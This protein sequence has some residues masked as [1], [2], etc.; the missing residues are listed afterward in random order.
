M[1]S[2]YDIDL[3]RPEAVLELLGVDEQDLLELVNQGRL[4]AYRID[5]AIRFRAMEVAALTA[6]SVT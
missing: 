4:P 2:L 6:Q 5:G 3:V 1:T